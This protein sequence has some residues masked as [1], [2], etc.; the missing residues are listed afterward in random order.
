MG[1]MQM[2]TALE[3]ADETVRKLLPED[4]LKLLQRM[5]RYCWNCGR[6]G[7]H[8]CGVG[9]K[10]TCATCGLSWTRKTWTGSS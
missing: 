1:E 2:S 5:G 10:R 4:R 6:V 7:L 3:Y 8:P 9:P